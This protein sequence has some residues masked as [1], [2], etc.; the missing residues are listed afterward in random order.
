MSSVAVSPCRQH[1]VFKVGT[2]ATIRRAAICPIHFRQQRFY[3]RVSHPKENPMEN[4]AL[5]PART[6][7]TLLCATVLQLCAPLV[8]AA[9]PPKNQ[10]AQTAQADEDLYRAARLH[11]GGDTAA[12]ITIWRT[13]AERGNNDAAY[14]LA[15]IHQN[16]DGV[17][18]DAAAA[19]YWYRQAAERGD[20]ISQ[21]Q[22]GLM[23]QNGEGVP[24]DEA[25]AHAWYT[26]S[27]REHMHHHHTAQFQQ[28][29]QQARAMIDAR[30]RREAIELA[31]RDGERVVAELKRR[32][33]TVAE[34]TSHPL[35]VASSGMAA[36]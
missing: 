10:A 13:W 12:A 17:P 14:N 18:Y 20:K 1:R 25:K 9:E 26:M 33:A 21:V 35:T 2:P 16:A 5:S 7:A 27:R 28:W 30:D 6:L 3:H 19:L 22:L 34:A 15:L 36:R 4:H 23:Y 11:K 8:M 24:A 29:Q 32:A 31:R